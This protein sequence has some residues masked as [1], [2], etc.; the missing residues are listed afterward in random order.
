[1][2]RQTSA[3]PG[4]PICWMFVPRRRWANRGVLGATGNDSLCFTSH[5]LMMQL[6]LSKQFWTL[7]SFRDFASAV[8]GFVCGALIARPAW[9]RFRDLLGG[10][11]ASFGNLVGAH[12]HD[13]R[14]LQRD[15]QTDNRTNDIV[16]TSRVP[17]SPRARPL[18]RFID[19]SGVNLA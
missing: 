11:L 5:N 1:M 10:R 9:L 16:A 3:F 19:M 12:A 18:I 2:T 13:R 6:N 8:L 15:I 14:E 4:R 7:G 17:S